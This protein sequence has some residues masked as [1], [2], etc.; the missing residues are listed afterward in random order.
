MFKNLV[1][2]CTALYTI[3]AR[4]DKITIYVPIWLVFVQLVKRK[5]IQNSVSNTRNDSDFDK[6]LDRGIFILVYAT[7]RTGS[8]EN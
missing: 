7:L 6:P 8:F 5:A 3:L 2:E 1:K 4:R